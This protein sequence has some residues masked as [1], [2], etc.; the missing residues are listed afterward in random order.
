MGGLPSAGCPWLCVT[1]QCGVA[2]AG[3]P[4]CGP[5]AQL[6]TADAAW[7]RNVHRKELQSVWYSAVVGL[8]EMSYMT[9]SSCETVEHRCWSCV[10]C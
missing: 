4:T 2:Y 10:V 1:S 8:V 5:V 3:S 9:V 6:L 7:H